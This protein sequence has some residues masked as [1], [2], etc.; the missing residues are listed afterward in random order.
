MF[1]TQTKASPPNFVH[2]ELFPSNVGGFSL[3]FHGKAPGTM[4]LS[5]PPTKRDPPDFNGQPQQNF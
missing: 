2:R 1:K 4:L 3:T 5:P